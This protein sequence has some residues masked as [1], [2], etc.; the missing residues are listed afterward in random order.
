MPWDALT[1]HT[2]SRELNDTLATARLEKIRMPDASSVLL[3]F[4]TLN[5]KRNLIMSAGSIPCC[6]I[7]GSE[8]DTPAVPP[9][10]CMHLRKHLGGA[11]LERIVTDGFE[12]IIEFR[13]RT[14]NDL[15]DTVE[16]RLIA[17][18]MGKH[19]N[20]IAVNPDGKITDSVKHI[21]PSVSSKRLVLPNL[22]YQSPPADDRITLE[23]NEG[24]R[25][26][27]A[28]FSGGD[29]AKYLLNIVRGIAPVTAQEIIALS[30]VGITRSVPLIPIEISSVI[31]ASSEVLNTALSGIISSCANRH[32]DKYHDFYFRPYRSVSGE[33]VP[34][35]SLSAAIDAIMS[36]RLASSGFVSRLTALT[37]TV[38]SALKKTARKLASAEDKLTES[39]G[40]EEY[41]IKGE[42]LTANLYK[43]K[44]GDQKAALHNYYTD[45]VTE[46]TL[47]ELRTPQQNAQR[48]YKQYNRLKTGASYAQAAYEESA[49]KLD[50]LESIVYSLT[51]AETSEDIAAISAE[52]EKAGIIKVNRKR[53][54]K[55]AKP[56]KTPP[57]RPRTYIY[58]DYTIQV[59][60]NNTANDQLIKSAQPED[61]WLHVKDT[62]G[63][64]T[65]IRAQGSTLPPDSVLTFAAGLA[66]RF[67]QAAASDKTAVDFT[68]IKHVRKIA[69]A[70]AGKVTY[71]HAT[72]VMIKPLTQDETDSYL[73]PDKN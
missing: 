21:T 36:N 23:D 20:I 47:D 53:S 62:H 42:L 29:L 71:S 24:L 51:G 8:F 67:S 13:F 63:S 14:K 12:R 26:A 52:L 55:S 43:L 10:F 49:A 5:G 2:I 22:Q 66:A 40:A 15:H 64:H 32:S 9:A 59:G 17:E 18:L 45:T 28:L 30:G 56:A 34:F 19:S 39:A 48:Y 73:R 57:L 3:T 54:N 6:Y 61:I 38:N 65:V 16:F 11:I 41:R 68:R 69:G 25:T 58:E 72:S 46:I 37:S 27:L 33:L 70:P 31:Q 44:K 35:E 7:T 4:H 1:I 60:R 50:Y